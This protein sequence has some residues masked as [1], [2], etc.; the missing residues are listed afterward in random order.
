MPNEL[1]QVDHPPKTR[2]LVLS[3]GG[4]HGAYQVGVLKR[5]IGEYQRQYDIIAGVSVGS[6]NAVHIAQFEPVAQPIGVQ[7]LEEFWMGIKGNSSIFKEWCLGKMAGLWKGGMVNP[8]PL[9]KL[10]RSNVNPERLKKSGV[11]LR[12]GA[13][14]L[15]TGL[16]KYVTETQENIIEWIMASAAEPG[17]FPPRWID[18][19]PW[20]DGGV[21]D[22]TPVSDVLA[23]NPD[24]I[25]VVL[26]SLK[27]GSPGTEDPEKMKNV[28][29]L[30]LRCASLL[31]D[32]V[33]V[34]DL[35][36]IPP[37][38]KSKVTIY[39]PKVPL[40]YTSMDFSPVKITGAIEQGW[41]D[42]KEGSQKT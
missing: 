8:A 28:A 26:T 40:P 9:E 7:E 42:A 19:D 37:E 18:G 35:A 24:H 14:N 17:A 39:A 1:G 2:A 38:W 27:D 5:L 22:V 36:L 32:E 20:T 3:G 15:K 16:Y 31:S 41:K 25:D 30:G 34:N 33:W 6:I 4:A 23:D 21:R 29:Y 11:K 12:V 10:L 13:V